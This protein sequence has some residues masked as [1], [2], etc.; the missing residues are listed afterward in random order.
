MLGPKVA[1]LGM[2]REFI[3]SSSKDSHR[4]MTALQYVPHW[5]EVDEDTSSSKQPQTVAHIWLTSS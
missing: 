3:L 1:W 5:L 2:T 4:L